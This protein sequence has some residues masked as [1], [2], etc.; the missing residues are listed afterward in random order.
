MTSA[1]KD[2]GVLNPNILATLAFVGSV[3]ISHGLI[4][5]F[6]EKLENVLPLYSW[7]LFDRP[8][9]GGSYYDLLV[10][11][12]DGVALLSRKKFKNV[13]LKIRSWSQ[14][15]RLGIDRSA[16]DA[17]RLQQTLQRLGYRPLSLLLIK[18]TLSDYILMSDDATLAHTEKVYEFGSAL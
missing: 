13:D 9:T 3:S 7:Q 11:S 15:Q 4:P 1:R 16:E 12:D 14:T 17:V 2:C 5:K 18:P 6:Y 10:E 8:A